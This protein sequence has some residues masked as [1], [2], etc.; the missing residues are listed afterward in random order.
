VQDAQR[1]QFACSQEIEV[2]LQHTQTLIDELTDWKEQL[3]Q[4]SRLN[5]ERLKHTLEANI[6]ISEEFAVN[7]S[8]RSNM[9]EPSER[10]FRTYAIKVPDYYKTPLVPTARM[11]EMPPEQVRF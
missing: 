6:I 3:F 1:A 9:F 11:E 5:I 10:S 7:D 2:I 4:I 8:A